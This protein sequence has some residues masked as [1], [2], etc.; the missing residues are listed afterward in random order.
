MLFF[1]WVLLL[2]TQVD[3]KRLAQLEEMKDVQIFHVIDNSLWGEVDGSALQGKFAC[4]AVKSC[5][6]V[7]TDASLTGKSGP[8]PNDLLSNI[9]GKFKAL[10]SPSTSITVGLYNIHTWGTKSKW[11][12]YPDAC[13]LPTQLNMVESEESTVRFR[14][15]FGASFPG[16]DG[17]STTHPEATVQRSYVGTGI[18]N[19]SLFIP[20][21]PFDSLIQGAAYVA[22]TCHRG[23]NNPKREDVVSE[24]EQLYRV[25]SL[26]KCHHR[27]VDNNNN[28]NKKHDD[29][30]IKL[31]MGKTAAETLRLKQDAISNYLFYLAFENTI[32]PGY[33]TEKVFDAL[34][35]GTVPVY[36]GASSDCKKMLPSPNAAI[37][38]DDFNGNVQE[39]AKYLSAVAQNATAYNL[40]R[41][42]WRESFDPLRLSPLIATPWPCR[43]CT[44]AAVQ[45]VKAAGKCLA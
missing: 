36:L 31:K 24:L 4:P 5:R 9:K 20:L 45:P 40:H 39:L 2:L 27:H 17:N 23:K 22:S 32:E 18:F 41:S 42:A 30:K 25:D 26:G 29:S 44:W 3:T 12:H 14:R 8:P 7:S 19:A 35:A 21:K 11:P 13:L 15:L 38:L 37:F 6:L 10:A 28:N 1:F 43:I 33:V 16:F 34:I